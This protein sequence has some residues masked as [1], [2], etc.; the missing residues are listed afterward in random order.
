MKSKIDCDKAVL[1]TIFEGWYSIPNY[2]RPYVWETE[3]VE[4]LLNCIKNAC[5]TGE[6][7]YFLGS[8]V[9]KK[10]NK[11]IDGLEYQEFEL[12]DGQ[13]RITTLFLIIACI[14]DIVTEKKEEFS[15][16]DF[17]NI[18][19]TCEK[20]IYQRKNEY[21]NIPEQLRIV[22][23]IRKE[24][25]EFVDSYIKETGSTANEDEF[26]KKEKDKT[27]NTSIRHMSNAILVARA[28]FHENFA[29]LK[30]FF[31]YLLNSVLLVYIATE[32]L[33]DAFQLFT[34]MNNTGLK[35]TNS[36]IFKADNLKAV[37][38]EAKQ[39]EWAT[40][41]EEMESYFGDDFDNFLSQIRTI[42]VKR[43]A[44]FSLIKEFNDII[45]SEKRWNRDKKQ[46]EACKAYLKRGEETFRFIKEYF[47]QYQE[48]FDKDHYEE[49]KS[50][51]IFNYLNLM[52]KGFGTDYWKASVLMY[53]KKFKYEGFLEFLKKLDNKIACDWIIGLVPSMRINNINDILKCI[54]SSEN[55]NGVLH[56]NVFD[57]NKDSFKTII[58]DSIYGRKYARYLLMKVDVLSCS[59]DWKYNLPSTISIEHILPQNPNDDSLWK[60]DFT[61]VEREEWTDRIGNLVLISRRK[62]SSQGNF[63]YADKHSKYFKNNI[64][65][66][67]AIVKLF[68]I[69]KE[70]K[71]TNLLNR[72]NEIVNLLVG[73]I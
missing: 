57:V 71:L 1:K 41:W 60:K 35:L 46:W 28:F 14:R 23:N 2:Q 9:Y 49:T 66:F 37:E 50:Y 20:L 18:V 67:P 27:V 63:D 4:E 48:I 58:S 38:D 13:Q 59:S 53:Y 52:Q 15:E 47:I 42:L 51:E 36:D 34:V 65:L 24:V 43:K 21:E 45:Y 56:S 22:F 31:K 16:I 61:D 55:S 3:Q 12:L 32:D 8:I 26:R 40:N 69:N 11:E 62:N 30:D 33:Q 25:R 6:G 70:W 5:N 68:E 39:T 7:E 64:E 29:L 17:K 19:S 44:D 72:Q 54:E 73:N 10:T